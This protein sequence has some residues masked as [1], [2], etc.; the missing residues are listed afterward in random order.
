MFGFAVMFITGVFLFIT[1]AGKAY[2]NQFFRTKLLLLLALGINALFRRTRTQLSSRA[3]IDFVQVA[4]AVLLFPIASFGFEDRSLT[5]A[6]QTTQFHKPLAH[7]R[8]RV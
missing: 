7:A 6:G 4:L 2:G 8:N 5:V 1:Q 3:F